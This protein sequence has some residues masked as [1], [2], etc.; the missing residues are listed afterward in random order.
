MLVPFE[1]SGPASTLRPDNEPRPATHQPDTPAPP[2]GAGENTSPASAVAGP[3]AGSAALLAKTG[4][5]SSDIDFGCP[6][7]R[8]G[9]CDASVERSLLEKQLQV[10]QTWN[11]VRTVDVSTAKFKL[12]NAL[13]GEDGSPPRVKMSPAEV[14]VLRCDLKVK[15]IEWKIAALKEDELR[16][17]LRDAWR[18]EG[19]EMQKQLA[20]LRHTVETVKLYPSLVAMKPRTTFFFADCQHEGPWGIGRWYCEALSERPYWRRYPAEKWFVTKRGAQL[21]APLG[22]VYMDYSDQDV[23]SY[24]S[25]LVPGSVGKT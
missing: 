23:Y 7:L 10:A 25:N 9:K 22:K 11:K 6:A 1:E 15:E 2:V 18:K 14:E 19:E 3:A 21:W 20:T 13:P 16:V 17:K 24:C 5:A 12:L 4:L 8:D